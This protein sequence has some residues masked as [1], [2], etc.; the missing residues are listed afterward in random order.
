[1][2]GNASNSS[3]I[4]VGGIYTISISLTFC[5]SLSFSSASRFSSILLLFISVMVVMITNP[6]FIQVI[7]QKE[8]R[9]RR[10]SSQ[11]L[12][13]GCVL[14]IPRCLLSQSWLCRRDHLSGLDRHGKVWRATWHRQFLHQRPSLF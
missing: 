1:M 14:M 10:A 4:F 12:V 8:F 2:A 11:I 9:D 6:F 13:E 3:T 7:D 5:S